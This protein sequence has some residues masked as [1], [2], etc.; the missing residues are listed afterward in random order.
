MYDIWPS[1]TAVN[2][3]EVYCAMDVSQ[4][5]GWIVSAILTLISL[6]ENDIRLQLQNTPVLGQAACFYN[7]IFWKSHAGLQMY[8][9]CQ[10]RCIDYKHD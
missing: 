10:K 1:E 3:M 4:Q 5:E 7:D 2:A 9:Y 8:G 6:F